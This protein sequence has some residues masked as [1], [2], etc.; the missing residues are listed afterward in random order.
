[1]RCVLVNVHMLHVIAGVSALSDVYLDAFRQCVYIYNLII[2][3]L[4]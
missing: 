1:M 3:L 2:I 4:N